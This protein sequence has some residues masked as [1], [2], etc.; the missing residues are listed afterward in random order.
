MSSD[1]AT[2][3]LFI[4]KLDTLPLY[5][6]SNLYSF[7]LCIAMCG[8]WYMATVAVTR[9]ERG[10]MIAQQSNQI[11]RLDDKFYKVSS[12]TGEGMYDV[13]RTN[14]FAMGWICDCPD[15]THRKVK[16]KHIWAVEFSVALRNKVKRNVVIEPLS[17]SVCPYCASTKLVR[18]GLRHNK[19]GNLQRFTCRNCRKRFAQNLGFEGMKANPQSITSA[20]QLYFTG[21]SLRNVQ[22]F[23]RLQGVE[24]H[25][26]TVYRWIGKY[27]EI[28]GR[29]LDQMQPQVGNTWRAD[30]LFLK[31]KGDMKYLYA[32]MDDETR[33]WIAKEVADTK[34]HADVHDLFKQG[35]KIAGKAPFH[36]ITDGAPN[37]TAGISAEFWREKKQLA[38]V[39]ERDI[40]FGG[41]IHNNKMERLNGEI[42][43]REKVVRG[44]KKSDSP[45][46]D[47][48]QIYHN[49][50]RP[51]MALDGKTPADLAGIEVQGNDKWLTLIQAASRVPKSNTKIEKTGVP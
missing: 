5:S 42:R 50:V 15:C 40:R 12:Q 18:H 26:T 33:F 44:V 22:K 17:P 34:Y 41:Q 29:Y 14:Q 39:H 25:H 47:G 27:V 3:I 49:Y 37:F 51:H 35:R 45:L 23:L 13:V 9:E 21:E 28:M 19:Y 46:I 4:A 38:L 30:E 2:I 43:D 36:I 8:D 1:M 31:V 24:V 32:L 20:M 48:Y 11:Q 7:W 6:D 16:C 10:R